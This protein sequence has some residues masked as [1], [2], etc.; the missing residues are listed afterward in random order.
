[1]TS[2]N[3]GACCKF[4][5][6]VLVFYLQNRLS[7]PLCSLMSLLLT[8]RGSLTLESGICMSGLKT[9][10]VRPSFVRLSASSIDPSWVYFQKKHSWSILQFFVGHVT[11]TYSF[12][13]LKIK[14]F[15]F[16]ENMVRYLSPNLRLNAFLRILVPKTLLSAPIN[17]PAEF[18]ISVAPCFAS[19]ILLHFK[20]SFTL[21]I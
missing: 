3:A 12:F 10:F 18:N 21:A 15:Y 13:P 2:K 1:M 6:I 9:S 5:R 14:S 4:I 16:S 20:V 11:I 8:I 17:L 7:L 19:F